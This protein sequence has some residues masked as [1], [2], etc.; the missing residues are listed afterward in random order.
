MFFFTVSPDIAQTLLHPQA[1]LQAALV[2]IEQHGTIAPL[3]FIGLYIISTVA[4]WPGSLLTLGAGLVFG[5]AWGAVYVF[6]GATIGSILAFLVGRYVARNWIAQKVAQNERFQKIDIAVQKNG[7]KIVFLTRL[8]PLFPFN[9][10]NYA[11]G[12]TAVRLRD[13]AI[14]S[15]GMI[16][17]TVMYVYLG[18]LAGSLANLGTVI[19]DPQAAIAQQV[20]RWIGG[21]A[22][23]SVT[24]YITQIARQALDRTLN[25]HAE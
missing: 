15:I 3:L 17:G 23:I 5:V 13:Y 12:L 16:P 20:L 22:T 8:S 25:N 2:W 11:Y 14:A 4:F 24:L 7:L 21:I 9:L 19:T 18:S 6:V 1:L 10:L